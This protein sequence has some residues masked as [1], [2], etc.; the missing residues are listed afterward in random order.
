METTGYDDQFI[1]FCQHG[2]KILSLILLPAYPRGDAPAAKAAFAGM[3]IACRA[4]DTVFN[5]YFARIGSCIGYYDLHVFSS[6]DQLV[7]G[8]IKRR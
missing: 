3:N 8:D 6:F 1:A 2:A 4:K 7:K 5:T